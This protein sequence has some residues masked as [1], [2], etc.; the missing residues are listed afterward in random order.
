MIYINYILYQ[1]SF[2]GTNM[3]NGWSGRGN[4]TRNAYV[5]HEDSSGS[6]SGSAVA[7]ATN[8]APAALGSETD[9][10]IVSPASWASIVGLKTTLGRI[11]TNGV[12]P[13]AASQDVV[14]GLIHKLL[15]LIWTI[16]KICCH[17]L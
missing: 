16:M 12:I 15:N 3:P 4:R 7:V 8:L 17:W 14:R 1:L 9:G 6:S 2:R 10:S 5:L 13:L 11:S